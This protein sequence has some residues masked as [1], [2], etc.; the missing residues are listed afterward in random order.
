MGKSKKTKQKHSGA[1]LKIAALGYETA[2]QLWAAESQSRMSMYNAMLITTSL[3]LAI[4]G[5]SYQSKLIFPLSN[6]FL[7]CLGIFICIIWYVSEKRQIEKAVDWL[8]CAREIEVRYFHGFFD[9][10]ERG[11]RFSKGEDVEFRI[12]Q[13]VVK[14]LKWPFRKLRSQVIFRAVIIL[15]FLLFLFILCIELLR[16]LNIVNI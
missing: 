7:P 5:F 14:R 6:F 11:S 15:W 8:Y 16:K 3:I 10:L 2:I 1:E 4:I 9:I 13:I 12:G